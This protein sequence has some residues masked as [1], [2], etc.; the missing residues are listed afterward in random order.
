[1]EASTVASEYVPVAAL[2]RV[3]AL[4]GRHTGDYLLVLSSKKKKKKNQSRWA[5]VPAIQRCRF[6]REL[7]TSSSLRDR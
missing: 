7:S 3:G 1:M 5:G 4:R 2:G 6:G